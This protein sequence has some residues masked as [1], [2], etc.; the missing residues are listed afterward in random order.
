MD[1]AL[2]EDAGHAGRVPPRVDLP[3][4]ELVP[5][6]ARGHVR[7]L[8]V[9]GVR[10]EA[11]EAV[12]GVDVDDGHAAARHEGRGD[13]VLRLDGRHPGADVAVDLLAAAGRR[14][15]DAEAAVDVEELVD[16]PRERRG[17]PRL[18]F[19]VEALAALV[20]GVALQ[21]LPPA[22]VVDHHVRL[23]RRR[24]VRERRVAGDLVRERVALAPDGRVRLRGRVVG[25]VPPDV[26]DEVELRLD[27][28]RVEVAV[29]ERLPGVLPLRRL[30]REDALVVPA[31]DAVVVAAARARAH[32]L[33]A[34][35]LVGP[36][37]ARREEVVQAEEAVAR[38]AVAEEGDLLPAEHALGLLPGDG[39]V[40]TSQR[41]GCERARKHSYRIRR[42]WL[43]VSVVT[44]G[45]TELWPQRGCP[46]A[47]PI[48]FFVAARASAQLQSMVTFITPKLKMQMSSYR[49]HTR[50]LLIMNSRQF[51]HD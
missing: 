27:G 1:M 17:V 14:P 6:V 2:S 24:D 32:G 37:L 46:R 9:E 12:Q 44:T 42:R 19:G 18:A 20:G 45:C 15:V 22:H 51:T 40:S 41:D 49:S 25:V 21:Q 31:F 33:L 38:Q 5:R 23:E 13:A 3:Q 35:E 29:A 43:S 39:R 4:D 10:V 16:D 34:A 30:V 26:L 28:P 11:V 8:V 7:V 48:A 36:E 47:I 50:S